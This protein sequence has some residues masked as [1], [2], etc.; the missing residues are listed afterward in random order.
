[1]RPELKS[2]PVNQ[3]KLWTDVFQ[4][5]LEIET[6]AGQDPA[7]SQP[8]LLAF[9]GWGLLR[10]LGPDRRALI[11]A[12]EADIEAMT[13]DLPDK[14]PFVHGVE[15]VE[16]AANLKVSLRGSPYRLG[17]EAPRGFPTILTATP[18][19]FSK[20]SGRLDLAKAIVTDPLALRV[21]VNRLWKGHLGTGIVDT[22]S[23]FGKNGD[24]PSHPELLDY[25]VQQFVTHKMSIKAMHREIMLSRVYQLSTTDSKVNAEKDGGNRLYWRAN[26]HRLTAEQIRDSVLFVSGTLDTKMGGPSIP[27]TPLAKRRTVYG[28]VSRYKLDEFLQLFDFPSPSQSAEKRFSTNVPLQRLFFMNSTSCNST[29]SARRARGRRSRRCGACAEGVSTGLWSRCYAG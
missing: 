24:R 7:L 23:N 9:S 21:I 2:L 13:K 16:T 25:L 27:L 19:T 10:Q 8:G 28:K 29:P 3:T 4:R 20:G 11:E 6:V 17:D 1:V 26:V 14:Y 12:L 18:L 5:D 15:D 22:P